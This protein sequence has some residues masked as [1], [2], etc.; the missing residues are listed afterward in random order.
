MNEIRPQT[1]K[2]TPQLD[3]VSQRRRGRVD[4]EG[5]GADRR[6]GQVAC[7]WRERQD[8]H[9]NAGSPQVAYEWAILTQNDMHVHVPGKFGEES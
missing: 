9:R 8:M 5:A 4:F 6:S 7:G 1:P 2:L 3:D